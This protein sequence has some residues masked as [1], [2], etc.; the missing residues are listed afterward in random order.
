MGTTHVPRAT[1]L[2]T[3]EINMSG[4]AIGHQLGLFDSSNGYLKKAAENLPPHFH[5]FFR[6]VVF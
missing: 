2:G 1:N 5:K 6:Q 3:S 4:V